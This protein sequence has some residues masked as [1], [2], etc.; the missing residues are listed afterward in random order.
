[1]EISVLVGAEEVKSTVSVEVNSDV[2]GSGATI[3]SLDVDSAVIVGSGTASVSSS[4]GG[5]SVVG[6]GASVG[7]SVVVGSG[8]GSGSSEVDGSGSD[9]G[10]LGGGITLS[11]TVPPHSSSENSFGQQPASVH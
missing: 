6:S 9:V 10:W 4:M 8:S 7:S 3:G 5:S 11:V 1:M 2:V